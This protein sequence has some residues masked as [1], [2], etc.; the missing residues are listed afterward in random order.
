MFILFVYF[1][2]VSSIYSKQLFYYIAASTTYAVP[3]HHEV[4]GSS[5]DTG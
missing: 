2:L 5:A 3:H 1:T 4:E